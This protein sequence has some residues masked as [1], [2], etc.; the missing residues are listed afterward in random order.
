MTRLIK[1]I[2]AG[3]VAVAVLGTAGYMGSLGYL[4]AK[5]ISTEISPLELSCKTY[6]PLGSFLGAALG[7]INGK[8]PGFGNLIKSVGKGLEMGLGAG[9]A[10]GVISYYAGYAAAKIF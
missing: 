3:T 2:Q 5:G 1:E 9:I 4:Q 7:G 6:V 10:I 8:N